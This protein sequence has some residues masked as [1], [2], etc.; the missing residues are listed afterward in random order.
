MRII[1]VGGAA[2]LPYTELLLAELHKILTRVSKDVR[3]PNF[4]HCLFESLAALTEIISVSAPQNIAAFEKLMYPL[5]TH[6][7]NNDISGA[8]LLLAAGG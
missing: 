1:S 2:V 7:L 5:F 6:I 8:F 3:N 4:N